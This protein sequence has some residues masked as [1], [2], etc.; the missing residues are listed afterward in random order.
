MLAHAVW[1]GR[2]DPSMGWKHQE[3]LAN[4][5]ALCSPGLGTCMPGEGP[6]EGSLAAR[7]SVP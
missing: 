6:A 1:A 5:A 3:F 7:A 4:L 2:W